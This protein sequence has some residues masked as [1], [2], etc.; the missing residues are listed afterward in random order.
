MSSSVHA[1]ASNTV[2]IN[3]KR[4]EPSPYGEFYANSETVWN[5]YAGRLYCVFNGA[6]SIETYWTLR[7]KTV[8]YDVP[9][10]PV[11]IEG[12]DVFPLL[13]RIFARRISNLDMGRGRYTIACTPQGGVFMDGVLFRMAEDRF[14]YVQPD[15]ALE[16]W[17][18]AHSE[19]FDVR[20]SDP[21]S[22]VL[23]VQGPTSFEVMRDASGGTIDEKM[24]YFH[25]GVFE[26]GGQELYVSRTGWTGELGFEIYSQ[27]DGTDYRAL[28]NHLMA[29]GEP[30]G[31][32][33]DGLQSMEMRRMEAAI[34]DN[35]TDFDLSMT[36]FEAGL[37]AFIDL[38]KEGFVG[39][40]AL[41]DAD[42][43]TLMYGIKCQ[44]IPEMH[45]EV[46]DSDTVVGRMTGGAWS[47]FLECGI[48]YVRFNKPNDW[49]GRTLALRTSKGE[50]HD[51]EI[52][53]LP[54]YDP[55]KRIP[56]GLDQFPP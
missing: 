47:P 33:F 6:D 44:V 51:C 53:D 18:V 12:P 9:E 4:F 31:M 25:S 17:L 27:G 49:A 16:P 43:R 56:R 15:G 7:R 32:V 22:R 50:F 23:Q 10:R 36:P 3:S 55:E 40:D 5:V 13:E 48:G 21:K 11:Q 34:L 20:I 41:L 54:F 28:W 46:F 38:D 1:N 2:R 35:L 45:L 39:R 19:G 29:A 52:V 26:L 30:H 42:R 8:L 37:G 14:W 24:K